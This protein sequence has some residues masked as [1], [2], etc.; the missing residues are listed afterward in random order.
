MNKTKGMSCLAR[1]TDTKQ[2]DLMKK[3]LK[4]INLETGC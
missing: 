2:Q 4:I 1:Q 3:Y